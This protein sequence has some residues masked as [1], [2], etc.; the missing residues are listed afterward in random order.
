MQVASYSTAPAAVGGAQDVLV[1]RH[2]DGTLRSTDWHVVFSTLGKAP[3]EVHAAALTAVPEPNPGPDLDPGHYPD[4][5]YSPDLE[6]NRALNPNPAP[7][8]NPT[9][10]QLTL[11]GQPVRQRMTTAAE[12]LP[13]TFEVPPTGEGGAAG[14]GAP[15]SAQPPEGMLAELVAWGMLCEGRNEL[16]YALAAPR[17]L[18]PRTL[19]CPAPAPRARSAPPLLCSLRAPPQV[20]PRRWRRRAGLA[21][22]VARP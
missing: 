14:A 20:H 6:P 7:G 16:R 19:S 5:G 3:A 12:L 22:L 8:P 2:S 10:V 13:A 18:T 9:Q 21:L 11:N 17:T 4:P 15:G 1:V